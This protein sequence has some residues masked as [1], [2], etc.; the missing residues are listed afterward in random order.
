MG[1]VQDLLD[2]VMTRHRVVGA[3]AC[4]LTDQGA[5]TATSGFA[6]L[7][8]QEQVSERTCFAWGSTAKLL[9]AFMVAQ[10]VAEGLIALDD[11]LSDQV[12]WFAKAG[13]TAGD[14]TIRQLLSHTSG[15]ADDFRPLAGQEEL[16]TMVAQAEP[17]AAP[18]ERF[19]Y[20]NV[21]Y[22]LLG[23]LIEVT[24]GMTW[25]S[26]LARR[27][28]V[29]SGLSVVR[30]PVAQASGLAAEHRLD[31]HGGTVICDSWPRVGSGFAAAGSTLCGSAADLARLA[32]VCLTGTDWPQARRLL[33]AELAMELQTEYATV[34]GLGLFE[35]GW[36]LGWAIEAGDPRSASAHR[37]VGHRG[38]TSALVHADPATA[39]VVAVLTNTA[40]GELLGRELAG[41]L[42][43]G[44][45]PPALNGAPLGSE[46]R[47]DRYVGDYRCPAFDLPV[48]RIDGGL[49]IAN[50]LTGRSVALSHLADDV[51]WADFGELRTTVAFLDKGGDGRPTRVH[52]A[53]R[54]LARDT[55]RTSREAGGRKD[56]PVVASRSDLHIVSGEPLRHVTPSAP[57]VR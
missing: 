50:P 24:T 19:S 21:G 29:P 35:S 7:D 30:T 3:S 31:Q 25:E 14:M 6:R 53:L 4:V 27:L 16:A 28:L 18:G 42:F 57:K 37:L 2:D 15:L 51:F 52:A 44:P 36:G 55:S 26:N 38:G 54:L 45:K 23:H 1:G 40:G 48:R 11:R 49:E 33:P 20:S 10:L 9:T 12:P 32:R 56:V 17:V 5:V 8:D 47:L 46:S 41:G 13:P 39:M 43:G 22:V 34:P